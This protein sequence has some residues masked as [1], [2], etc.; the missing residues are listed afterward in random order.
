MTRKHTRRGEPQANFER[1]ECGHREKRPSRQQEC[2]RQALKQ[3]PR[4]R[5]LKHRGNHAKNHDR[6]HECWVRTKRGEKPCEPRDRDGHFH[7]EPSRDNDAHRVLSL[8]PL[9]FDFEEPRP[10]FSGDEQPILY[11]VV[12]NAV[13]HIGA[14][15]HGRRK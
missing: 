10:E 6:D 5:G 15:P 8:A 1:D 2:G 13:Q 12:C 9:E 14:G 11:R 7:R 4:G 3:R